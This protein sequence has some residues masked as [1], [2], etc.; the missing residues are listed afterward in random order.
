LSKVLFVLLV[1]LDDAVMNC[2]AV[3]DILVREHGVQRPDHPPEMLRVNNRERLHNSSNWWLGRKMAPYL[4]ISNYPRNHVLNKSLQIELCSWCW[5]T[6]C[7][8][9]DFGMMALKMALNVRH[10]PTIVCPDFPAPV[11]IVSL[12]TI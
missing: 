1:T 10:D 8:R 5:V 2:S 7:W 11:G 12:R 3:W 6:W 4:V 9:V